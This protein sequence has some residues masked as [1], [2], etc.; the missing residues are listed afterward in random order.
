[1]FQQQH[2][3]PLFPLEQLPLYIKAFAAKTSSNRQLSISLNFKPRLFSQ[4]RFKCSEPNST[5]REVPDL[6]TLDLLRFF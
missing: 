4:A 3:T 5:V 1:M 6:K 2:Q